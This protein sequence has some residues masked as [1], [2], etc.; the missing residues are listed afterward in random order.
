MLR[1]VSPAYFERLLGAG[2]Y[3]HWFQILGKLCRA[4]INPMRQ[5]TW[6]DI[7]GYAQLAL[8]RL[9]ENE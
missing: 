3:Y 8:D 2:V 6:T 7:V 5:D 9:K 1:A 4:A